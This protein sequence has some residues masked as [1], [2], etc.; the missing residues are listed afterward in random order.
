MPDEPRPTNATPLDRIVE[1]EKSVEQL[2]KNAS[3][4][5]PVSPRMLALV[6]VVV[7]MLIV[8]IL[9]GMKVLT[10]EVIAAILGAIAGRLTSN[11][12]GTTEEGSKKP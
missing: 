7:L 2:S 4:R 12:G 10:V 11:I 5:D 3:T 6:T 8:G 9:G 1:L